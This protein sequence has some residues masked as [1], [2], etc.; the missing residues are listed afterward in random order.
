MAQQ[1]RVGDLLGTR[2]IAD[3]L[4]GDDGDVRI[5]VLDGRL[6]GVVALVGDVVGG[7]VKDPADRAGA[8]HGLGQ[9]VRRLLAHLEQVVGDDR[10]VVDAVLVA[11]R[12]IG[13]EHQLHAVGDRCPER[14]GGGH[15]IERQRQDDAGLLDQR[16]LDVAALLG[17]VERGVGGGDDLDSQAVE[18]VGR[19]GADRIH[20]I[21]LVVPQQRGGVPASLECRGACV[22]DGDGLRWGRRFPLRA[23]GFR[24]GRRRGC[25]GR[26]DGKGRKPAYQRSVRGHVMVLLEVRREMCRAG[27][28]P[29]DVGVRC[30]RLVLLPSS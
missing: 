9:S 21:R 8:A 14:F 30:T 16:G 4:L 13:Q 27:G 24:H 25:E 12:E 20:E 2:R 3:A 18:L 29:V 28:G 19:A 1:H 5:V 22:G 10:G 17:G 7:V 6:E 26:G 11:A 15:R 23:D